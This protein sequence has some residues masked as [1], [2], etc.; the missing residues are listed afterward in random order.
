MIHTLAKE[1]STTSETSGKLAP[2]P[3]LTYGME[4]KASG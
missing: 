4:L 1:K 3:A 2:T